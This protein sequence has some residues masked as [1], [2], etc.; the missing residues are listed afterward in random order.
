MLGFP[1]K[2]ESSNDKM[3]F[4]I[5]TNPHIKATSYGNQKP[6]PTR[7]CKGRFAIDLYA[8][9]CYQSATPCYGPISCAAPCAN[10]IRCQ[11]TKLRCQ[12]LLFLIA[13]SDIDSITHN[14]GRSRGGHLRPFCAW[15]AIRAANH[16]LLQKESVAK[17]VPKSWLYQLD[18]R[19]PITII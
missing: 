17:N 4:S 3:P 13:L 5:A 16:M 14:H 18:H 8:T 12:T 1:S 2:S 6:S 19:C 15:Y 10:R 11:T 7:Q 9:R